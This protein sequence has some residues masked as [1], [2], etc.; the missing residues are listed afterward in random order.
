MS[1][2]RAAYKE[3]QK[4]EGSAGANIE[5]GVECIYKGCS[6]LGC[7]EFSSGSSICTCKCAYKDGCVKDI[8]LTECSPPVLECNSNCSCSKKCPNRLTQ[9]LGRLSLSIFQ[10]EGKGLGVE[11]EISVPFGTYIGEYVGEIISTA[12]ASARLAAI[13][14]SCYI[15][16]YREHLS[17]GRIMTTNVDATN[18]GNMTRFINHSCDPNAAMIPVRVDSVLPRLCMFTSR[19]VP[20]GE[21]LC[22]SYLGKKASSSEASHV[23]CKRCLCGSS[24][25]IGFLPLQ[26]V[27]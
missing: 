27:D 18:K 11:T 5:T 26:S 7:C 16:Q 12:E 8:Y 20:A 4:C 6:C 1:A 24:N 2:E 10:T 13:T 9:T 22:F 23:G 17:D 21:E 3:I 14:E 19:A 25:C 15:V